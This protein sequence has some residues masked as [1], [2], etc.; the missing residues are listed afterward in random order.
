MA[1]LVKNSLIKSLI[2]NDDIVDLIAKMSNDKFK[3]N[4]VMFSIECFKMLLNIHPI[5]LP[6]EVMD[7]YD[8]RNIDEVKKSINPMITNNEIEIKEVHNGWFI[9][10]S[11]R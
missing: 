7:A 8:F 10:K 11:K 4:R 2:E 9:Y 1:L 6:I 5:I 3:P